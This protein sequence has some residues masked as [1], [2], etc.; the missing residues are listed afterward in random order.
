[1]AT[2]MLVSLFKVNTFSPKS[3]QS[4][5]QILEKKEK[6]QNLTY[7]YWCVGAIIA[8]AMNT[9][10]CQ[11]VLL[12]IATKRPGD[13]L[14]DK[15]GCMA[16]IFLPF[17]AQELIVVFCC[18]SKLHQCHDVLKTPWPCGSTPPRR[19]PSHGW[20]LHGRHVGRG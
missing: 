18:Q 20:T 16:L 15:Y 3:I 2:P 11:G 4:Y 6:Q 5:K 13:V 14:N 8:N 9:F 19:V 10:I 7:F 12:Q 17:V 1:M